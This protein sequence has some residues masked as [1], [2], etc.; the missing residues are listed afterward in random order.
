M[1]PVVRGSGSNILIM[2]IVDTLSE[3]SECILTT[4]DN[5]SVTLSF[6]AILTE[7]I[8]MVF[9]VSEVR[10]VNLRV[11]WRQ[12]DSFK[13]NTI[14]FIQLQ[15]TSNALHLIRSALHRLDECASQVN[16][17]VT[18]V[19]FRL[20]GATF[21]EYKWVILSLRIWN[22]LIFFNLLL[23]FGK[24][25]H[26]CSKIQKFRKTLSSVNEPLNLLG[27]LQTI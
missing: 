20:F 13:L 11:R 8:W 18:I 27:F 12:T 10:R 3:C 21:L 14:F 22:P 24:M 1:K 2:L 25:A 17:H 9:F 6:P 5:L 16:R 19:Y 15:Y 26:V 7:I 4:N 23:L